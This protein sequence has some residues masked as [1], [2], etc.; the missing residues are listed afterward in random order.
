M[1]KIVI[2]RFCANNPMGLNV[3]ACMHTQTSAQPIMTAPACL[4][5][6]LNAIYDKTVYFT[7]DYTVIVYTYSQEST[8][9][10]GVPYEYHGTYV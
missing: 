4:E 1:V 10:F 3:F 2:I 8:S 9:I 7:L 5:V 6:S